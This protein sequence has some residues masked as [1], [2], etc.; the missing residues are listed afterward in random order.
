MVLVLQ[1]AF[2]IDFSIFD[3][4]EIIFFTPQT[5]LLNS[6]NHFSGLPVGFLVQYLFGIFNSR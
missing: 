1:G 3:V 6:D 5:I 4:D 2:T